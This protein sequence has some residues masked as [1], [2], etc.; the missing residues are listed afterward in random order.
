MESL[1][2][3]TGGEWER[4][5]A[6]QDPVAIKSQMAKIADPLKGKE[7]ICDILKQETALKRKPQLLLRLFRLFPDKPQLSSITDVFTRTFQKA[8][9]ELSQGEKDAWLT[10]ALKSGDEGAMASLIRMGWRPTLE[11]FRE[12]LKTSERER[13]LFAQV[14]ADAAPEFFCKHF[15][16]FELSDPK[17][18]QE[19]VEILRGSHSWGP[20]QDGEIRRK[21]ADFS[22]H[23]DPLIFDNLQSYG[24][25]EKDSKEILE[26]VAQ[27]QPKVFLHH[28]SRFAGDEDQTF[29][30]EL[31]ALA[32]RNEASFSY[33]LKLKEKTPYIQEKIRALLENL[34]PERRAFIFH[35]GNLIKLEIT[36]KENCFEV[37]KKYLNEG[38]F[39][40]SFFNYVYLLP[41][42]DAERRF[43]LDELLAK[44]GVMKKFSP[45]FLKALVKDRE[46]REKLFSSLMRFVESASSREAPAGLGSKLFKQLITPVRPASELSG[47]DFCLAQV[48]DLS[49]KSQ[50][51]AAD[52]FFHLY[53]TLPKDLNVEEIEQVQKLL[54][55]LQRSEL[56]LDGES[57]KEKEP[58]SRLE[59]LRFYRK[60][61]EIIQ[62][63]AVLDRLTEEDLNSEMIKDVLRA[64]VSFRPKIFLDHL[65]AL[66]KHKDQAFVDELLLLAAKEERLS[67]FLGKQERGDYVQ[68]KIVLL[69]ESLVENRGSPAQLLR[70]FN[71]LSNLKMQKDDLYRIFKKCIEKL[72]PSGIKADYSLT[73]FFRIFLG[74]T[75]KELIDIFLAKKGFSKE[76]SKDLNGAFSYLF[77]TEMLS[78]IEDTVNGLTPLNLGISRQDFGI[79]QLAIG[80]GADA[81]KADDKGV[82]PLRKAV[83]S[84]TSVEIFELLKEQG[85]DLNRVEGDGHT[86]LTFAIAQGHLAAL[87]PLI[88][89]GADLKKLTGKQQLTPLGLA[90]SLGDPDM[91]KRLL[92][93]G[94]DP[95]QMDGEGMSSLRRAVACNAPPEIFELLK[96]QLNVVESDGHTALSYAIRNGNLGMVKL[97][98]GLGADIHQKIKIQDGLMFSEVT[99]LM[100]ALRRQGMAIASFLESRGAD[101]EIALEF[102]RKKFLAQVWGIKGH[103]SIVKNGITYRFNRQSNFRGVVLKTLSEYVKKFFESKELIRLSKEDRERIEKVMSNTVPISSETPGQLA[104]RAQAGEPIAILAGSN[105]HSV[106]IVLFQGKLAICNRGEGRSENAVEYFSLPAEKISEDLIKN[107]TKIYATT[108]E[109]NAYVKSLKLDWSGGFKQK[110]QKVGNCTV[111]SAKGILGI[112]FRMMT[113]E[114]I[115]RATY[116]Q[117]TLFLRDETLSDFSEHPSTDDG[118]LDAIGAKAKAKKEK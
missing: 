60:T 35:N 20:V 72:D 74:E 4:A 73:N 14:L 36:N 56:P 110:D 63:P 66:E 7:A 85:V 102:L 84:T 92:E 89:L 82:T 83:A 8:L 75:R 65:A 25:T 81:N 9:S 10:T 22:A 67:P 68:G 86:A 31:L 94:A 99:P 19:V 11:N 50:P 47:I 93:L 114:E 29:V 96:K 33:L 108:A 111:A 46:E 113:D 70:I 12:L 17:W 69:V 13:A 118:L 91:V 42:K 112:L 38:F 87:K 61:I 76:V 88:E 103:S 116:K 39:E 109:F 23:Y 95:T 100:E 27:W 43:L 79:V 57:L 62:D 21:I 15:T 48:L 107:L 40:Y 115:G 3:W 1:G 98:V 32:I 34:P 41:L 5:L 105:G 71:N 80:L 104:M 117:F 52:L 16:D 55:L 51:L 44:K 45:L 101:K 49:Q 18:A 59:K 24:L 97:L 37:L 64:V 78:D 53:P 77:F 106:S 58:S 26:V 54:D 6:S 2:T 30:D 28:L 90:I